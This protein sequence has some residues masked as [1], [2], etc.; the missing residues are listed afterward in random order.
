MLLAQTASMWPWLLLSSVHAAYSGPVEYSG[1]LIDHYCYDLVANGGLA[2][3]RT[4]VIRAPWEHTVGCLLEPPCRSYYLALDSGWGGATEYRKKFTLDEVGNR[5]AIAVLQNSA[6]VDNFKVT[7]RGVH[8]GNGTLINASIEECFGRNCDGVCMGSCAVAPSE[9]NQLARNCTAPQHIQ[10]STQMK[11]QYRVCPD[12]RMV[13]FTVNLD[14]DAWL[15]LGISA[16]GTMT[17]SGVGSD[18]M[19][20]S[21]GQV[22]RYWITSKRVPSG[23]AEVPGATCVHGVNTTMTFSRSVLPQTRLQRGINVYPGFETNVI[24]AH[25]SSRT[26]AYHGSSRGSISVRFGS[27]PLTS[28]E[29]PGRISVQGTVQLGQHMY[30]MYV[31]YPD[32]GRIKFTVQL[33]GDGWLGL[34]V[35]PDGTMTGSGAGSDIIACS[36]GAVKRYWVQVKHVSDG[37]EVPGS[38]CTQGPTSTMVFTRAAAAESNRQR[39]V[40]IAPGSPTTFIW[41][42][43]SSR[44][45][46]Y[47]EVTRGTVSVDVGS[48]GSGVEVTISPPNLVWAH[49]LLMLLAWAAILPS[50]VIW[51]RFQRD[52]PKQCLGKPVW[53]AV[54]SVGQ[55]FGVCVSVAGFACAVAYVQDEGGDHF[56]NL[57]TI[58]GLV[59]VLLGLMQPINALFR[60]HPHA[61]G[62][63]QSTCTAR[64]LWEYLHKGVGYTVIILGLI[65]VIFGILEAEERNYGDSI[66]PLTAAIAGTLV[67]VMILYVSYQYIREL[68]CVDKSPSERPAQ[69]Q[70]PQ[71]SPEPLD[72]PEQPSR[73]EAEGNAS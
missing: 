35:S 50:G 51:A 32:T 70:S 29:V 38:H 39:P 37:I 24:W 57:H 25:G 67:L 34:G 20:C 10:L 6:R 64:M 2:L 28:S 23:G 59:V 36:N 68:V 31:V 63:Q 22:S 65:N 71:H 53:F 21:N 46:S 62:E 5:N 18:V 19:V 17:S 14:A 11:L 43:G 47:H 16:D 4:D 7:A 8:N 48:G 55:M 3:D 42:H 56:D 13:S 33:D 12:E 9:T 61:N 54:H 72:Q 45:L 15:A 30:V 73:S 44:M 27:T 52:N 66:V 60:P 49:A 69:P 1:Y 26:L 58:W 41:A 40:S